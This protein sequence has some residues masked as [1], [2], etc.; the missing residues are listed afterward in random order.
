MNF[1]INEVLAGMMGAIKDSVTENWDE[2]KSVAN[3]F[4]GRRK[5]RLELL[6]E[7]R[8]SGE[9]S[10]KKFESRLKDEKLIIEAELHAIAV[11]TKA[12]AQKAANAA[13]EVLENAV[14]T[15]I[16]LV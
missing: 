6:A 2:V 11:I 4:L 7:L 3:E 13:I 15:A 14:K 12:I 8:I 10:Q 16:G 1:N 9:L 5:A